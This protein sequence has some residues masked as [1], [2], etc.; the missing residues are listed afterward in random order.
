LF[1]REGVL[2]L[3]NARFKRD[4]APPDPDC[5]CATCAQH[6]RAYIRHLLRVNDTLG[7][8][9]ATVHNLRFYLRLLEEARA[10]IRAGTFGA[11]REKVRVIPVR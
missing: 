7:A 6:S 1:T 9:L 3:R 5:D 8:R 2:K 11:L 10:A 4:A